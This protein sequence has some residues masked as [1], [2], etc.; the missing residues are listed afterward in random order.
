[1]A[2]TLYDKIL[3]NHLVAEDLIYIDHQLIHE[4][5]SPQAFEG[6]RLA[7]RKPRRP[8]AALAVADHNVPTTNDRLNGIKDEISR[9]QVETLEANCKE[10]A[11]NI[12]LWMMHAKALFI[13]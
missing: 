6:L 2:R 3:A 8:E 1:M 5:T 12:S 11:Y 7:G 4:V 13:S 9:K 10:F